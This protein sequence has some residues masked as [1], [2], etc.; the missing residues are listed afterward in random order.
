V[1]TTITDR[2]AKAR[3]VRAQLRELLAK[4]KYTAASKTRHKERA[5]LE[6][7]LRRLDL[8]AVAEMR[9]GQ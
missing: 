6:A 5:R 3:A 1:T 8:E 9:G 7:E 2:A 4:W